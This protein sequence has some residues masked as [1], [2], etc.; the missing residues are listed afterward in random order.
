MLNS[1]IKLRHG[2][3]VVIYIW[4]SANWIRF[5]WLSEGGK[6]K[7]RTRKFREPYVTSGTTKDVNLDFSLL[8]VLV[9]G[10][11]AYFSD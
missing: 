1:K 3:C 8:L 2:G 6:R 7:K 9:A 10:S 5:C 4:Q 11:F